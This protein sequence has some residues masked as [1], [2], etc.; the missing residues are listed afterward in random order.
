MPLLLHAGG[1]G[2]ATTMPNLS[3][4][5]LF[6]IFPLSDIL[7]VQ[8]SAFAGPMAAMTPS[9]TTEAAMVLPKISHF[10]KS[11]YPYLPVV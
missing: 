7:I 3:Q 4:A 10:M 9:A 8:L 1:P 5:L 11:F 2:T 6:S